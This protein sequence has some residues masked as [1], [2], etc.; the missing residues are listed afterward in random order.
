MND[1]QKAGLFKMLAYKTLYE[2]GLEFGLDKKYKDS[3]SVKGAV[4]RIYREVLNDP[5]KFIVSADTIEVVETAMKG[6]NSTGASS[7]PKLREKMDVL[8]KKDIKTLVLEGRNQS[9]NLLNKK[10]ERLN[11]SKKRLDNVSIGEL[12]KVFGILFDKSQIV[13]GEATEHVAVMARMSKD[14]D[15]MEAID[16]VLK[17]R[18]VNQEIKYA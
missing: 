4:Y 7:I 16:A 6:R 2:V 18:E 10:M 3:K 12:A 14:M 1:L 13:Q 9:Y 8:D 17:M 11:A 5:E 15:P